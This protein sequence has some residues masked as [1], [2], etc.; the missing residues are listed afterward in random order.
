M[1]LI[2]V[3]G[4]SGE[5]KGVILIRLGGVLRQVR[6]VVLAGVDGIFGTG[7]GCD[8]LAKVHLCVHIKYTPLCDHTQDVHIK[9]TPLCDHT[10]DVHIKPLYVTTPRMY[11]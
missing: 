7:E 1:V 9:Y 3:G 8:L 5:V 11:T 2:R 10:Q 4:V 6:G